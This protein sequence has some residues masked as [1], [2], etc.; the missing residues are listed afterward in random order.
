MGLCGIEG[1]EWGGAGLGTISDGIWDSVALRRLNWVGLTRV[2]FLDA[3]WDCVALGGLNG[4]GLT[5]VRFLK[6]QKHCID[7]VYVDIYASIQP[8]LRNLR[9]YMKRNRDP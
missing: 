3:V 2:R 6:N 4:V 9:Q 5:R 8:H 1:I 7:K